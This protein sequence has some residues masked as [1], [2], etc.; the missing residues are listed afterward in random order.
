MCKSERIYR[1]P[2]GSYNCLEKYT[3]HCSTDFTLRSVSFK[4]DRKKKR[5]ASGRVINVIL[6]YPLSV[7]YTTLLFIQFPEKTCGKQPNHTYHNTR[8]D[9]Y[10]IHFSLEPVKQKSIYHLSNRLG[11]HRNSGCISHDLP[12][13]PIWRILLNHGYRK[14]RKDTD[15][16]L[17]ATETSN[18]H[19]ISDQCA[20]REKEYN[21]CRNDTDTYRRKHI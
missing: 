6:L 14:N 5:Q 17:H 16:G 12:N 10:K 1:Y 20:G 7:Y 3:H 9:Q 19:G 2:F 13:Q 8:R 21:P 18:N 4:Q 15:R 11:A